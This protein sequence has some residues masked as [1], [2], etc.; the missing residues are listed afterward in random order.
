MSFVYNARWQLS[1]GTGPHG[2]KSAIY[3]ERS[4]PGLYVAVVHRQSPPGAVESR[5]V[6]YAAGIFSRNRVATMNGPE[7]PVGPY[8]GMAFGLY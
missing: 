4:T 3:H 8:T 5:R 6:I 1:T 7:R 2:A